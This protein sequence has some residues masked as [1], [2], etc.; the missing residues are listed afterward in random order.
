MKA[1]VNI[2]LVEDDKVDVKTV[3]RA[4]KENHIANGLDVVYNG[5]EALEYLRSCDS[6]SKRLP[7]LILL[8]LNMPVMN[9]VEFLEVVKKDEKFK[10][11]PVVVLTTSQE[12]NDRMESYN[13]GVAGYIIKPVEFEKFVEVV[14]II[15]LYWSLC[16]L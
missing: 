6:I 3:I 1:D 8:D 12:E 14:K 13:L 4:F 5:E 15:N 2:L 7:G 9:G 11:I 16:E 10:S